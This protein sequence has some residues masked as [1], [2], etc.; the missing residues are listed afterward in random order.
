MKCIKATKDSYQGKLGEVKRVSDLEADEKVKTGYWE[1]IPKQ[2]YKK[3]TRPENYGK[4]KTDKSNKS[5]KNEK[6]S[7]KTR[8]DI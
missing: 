2:E 5:G 8:L 7:K 1:Y 3:L 4:E 6:V